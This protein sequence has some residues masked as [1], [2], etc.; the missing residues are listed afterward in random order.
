MNTFT[1]KKQKKPKSNLLKDAVKVGWSGIGTA[2]TISVIPKI[3]KSKKLLGLSGVVGA[4]ITANQI[5]KQRKN[6][7][8]FNN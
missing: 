4:G 6:K 1:P 7:F 2:S 8:G 5:R 3:A